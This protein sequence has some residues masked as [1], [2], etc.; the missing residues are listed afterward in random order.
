[1]KVSSEKFLGLLKRA[2]TPNRPYHVQWMLTNRCNYRCKSCSVWRTKE[3]AKELPVD[4]VKRG[5]DV[6]RKLGVLEVV[7][8]GGNPL[9]RP[10]IDEILDYTSRF[11]I[12]TIYDNGSMA[13]E[14]IDALRNA[15]F[16]AV[17]LDTLNEKKHDYLRG[18]PGAWRKAMDAIETLHEEEVSVGVATTISQVNLYEIVHLTEHFISRDI[19]VWYSLYAY[20]Y[21]SKNHLFGI[22]ERDSEFEIVDTEAVVKLC[23]ELNKMKKK[24]EGVFITEKTLTALK[25][26]FSEK[27]RTWKCKALQNFFVIDP[28]G[29]VAGCHLHKPV[30]SIFELPEVWDSPRFENLRKKYER[31]TQC[32]YLCYLFYSIHAGVSGNIEIMRDQWRNIRLAIS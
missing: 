29:N 10:D 8:S 25:H 15:D 9:L 13:V 28:V 21:P 14:K 6:L 32:A 27:Q 23:D 22:G 7:L 3:K 17:S 5:L 20:D 30:A 26:F 2:V 31:C 19:P 1:M 4:E 12:T 11:F 24:K 18:V 16:V